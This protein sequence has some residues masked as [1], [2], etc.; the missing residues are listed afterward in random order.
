M[1]GY[2]YPGV[3]VRN[4]IMPLWLPLLYPGTPGTGYPGTAWSTA[5]MC[6]L[7]TGYISH[8]PGNRS[9]YLLHAVTISTNHYYAEMCFNNVHTPSNCS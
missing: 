6:T 4:S 5:I 2:K 1:Y 8:T 7:G 9:R 3:H